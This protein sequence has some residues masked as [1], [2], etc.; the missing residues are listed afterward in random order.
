MPHIPFSPQKAVLAERFLDTL[1]QAAVDVPA[2]HLT[3]SER[4]KLFRDVLFGH[5]R[6]R[7]SLRPR[8][9]PLDTACRRITDTTSRIHSMAGYAD[10]YG[11][12]SF[13]H[14]LTYFSL[15]N[16][17]GSPSNKPVPLDASQQL[18][19]VILEL[20]IALLGQV[21]AGRA[22]E[23][24]LASHPFAQRL[25]GVLGL[26]R[27]EWEKLYDLYG[28]DATRAPRQ[29]LLARFAALVTATPCPPQRNH[30]QTAEEWR[31]ALAAKLDQPGFRVHP[32]EAKHAL[33]NALEARLFVLTTLKPSAVQSYIA[34]G[35]HH[36]NFR[37]ASAWCSQTLGVARDLFVDF[38]DGLLSSDSDAIVAAWLPAVDS[39]ANLNDRLHQS[40]SRFWSLQRGPGTLQERCPRLA[41]WLERE[42]C[43]ASPDGS[44][45]AALTLEQLPGFEVRCKEPWSLL[46]ICVHRLPEEE[47]GKSESTRRRV[48]NIESECA[49]ATGHP[50][51]FT[52]YPPWLQ[53]DGG[54]R[55][56]GV[57]AIAWS[58]CGTTYRTHSHEG[59]CESLGEHDLSLQSVHHGEWLKTLSLENSRLTH[60]KI[61]GDGVGRRFREAA[62][63]DFP[64]LSME[65]ARLMQSRLTEGVRSALTEHRRKFPGLQVLTLPV[66]VVYLGGDDLYICVPWDLAEYFMGGFGATNDEVATNQWSD[67]RFTFIAARLQ[68]ITQILSGVD[69]ADY[70]ARTLRLDSANQAAAR[71]LTFGLRVVKDSFK[72]GSPLDT[73]RLAESAAE[74]TVE[75]RI[76]T[77]PVVFGCLRG[78]LVDV[79]CREPLLPG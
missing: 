64:W 8:D 25:I 11:T 46:E 20:V 30:F 54:R 49:H 38:A 26:S 5:A 75:I 61:D 3:E 10:A 74:P 36:W 42:L 31:A 71:L 18:C 37:G 73:T 13:R 77:D 34:Q 39:S 28:K 70:D 12:I 7:G 67:L 2:W 29:V 52:T 50:A 16:L 9:L 27:Q 24:K 21:P 56:V 45:I 58:L 23:E 57:A 17:P 59:L 19:C 68:P 53:P 33:L 1:R 51:I 44:G 76:D 32:G 47:K 79:D 35:K 72:S 48:A 6:V 63:A 15:L 14:W 55:P 40:I 41:E 78:R 22:V 69:S 60:L 43:S 62:L 4:W 65:L 66:D